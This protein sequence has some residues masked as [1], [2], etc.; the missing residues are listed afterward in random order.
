MTEAD[1]RAMASEIRDLI[2]L[3]L[4]SETVADLRALAARYERL[5]NYLKVGALP[6]VP[7]EHEHRHS[8]H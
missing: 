5:A 6:D 8:A 3:V 7:L 1:Y 2:P 4:H